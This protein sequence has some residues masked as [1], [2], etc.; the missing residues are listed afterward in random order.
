MKQ[1]K[2]GRMQ[3]HRRSLLRGLVT[4]VV[5]HGRITTTEAKAKSIKPLVDHMITLGK[6][7]DLHARR[8]AAAFLTKP[9]AVQKLFSEV[10]PNHQD[11]QGGYTRVL[12]LGP[13]PGDAAPMALIEIV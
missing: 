13:R 11:R 8:Q 6:R 9:E 3:G 1:R 5:I 12:K 10:A 2:L 4:A 7:G